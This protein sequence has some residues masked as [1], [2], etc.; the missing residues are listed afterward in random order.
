ML[1]LFNCWAFVLLMLEFPCFFPMTNIVL[2]CVLLRIWLICGQQPGAAWNWN[3]GMLHLVKDNSALAHSPGRKIRPVQVLSKFLTGYI[4][5][6][7]RALSPFGLGSRSHT[8]ML[9]LLINIANIANI[10]MFSAFQCGS[11]FRPPATPPQ[12]YNSQTGA[13]WNLG[14]M[15]WP[16][17]TT[18]RRVILSVLGESLN[19]QLP[20]R[21]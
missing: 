14:W 13:A 9:I 4:S 8:A 16:V 21:D 1:F 6:V 19:G 5:M 17:H 3:S 12:R 18:V 20:K 15:H 7:L 11:S 2:I 10:A